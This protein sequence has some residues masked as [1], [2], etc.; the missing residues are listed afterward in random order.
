MRIERLS[1]DV[2]LYIDTGFI[3]IAP[4]LLTKSPQAREAGEVAKADL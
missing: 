2:S 1:P 3:P 4:T